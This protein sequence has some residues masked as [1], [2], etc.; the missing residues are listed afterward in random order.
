MAATVYIFSLAS[1]AAVVVFAGA[2]DA[3][4][5]VAGMQTITDFLRN[6][7]AWFWIPCAV[8]VIFWLILALHLYALKP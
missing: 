3:M 2:M 7:P 5:T 4:M 6:F 1:L 8:T